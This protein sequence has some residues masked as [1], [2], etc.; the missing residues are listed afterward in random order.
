MNAFGEM[1]HIGDRC[2]GLPA[3]AVRSRVDA[4]AIVTHNAFEKQTEIGGGRKMDGR[5]RRRKT[6]RDN[7]YYMS[8]L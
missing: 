8:K 7:K 2:G 4:S 5:E 6:F 1:E 3:D